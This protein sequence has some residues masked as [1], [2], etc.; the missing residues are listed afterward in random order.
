MLRLPVC[1]DRDEEQL[2]P[3]L[4]MLW[5]KLMLVWVWGFSVEEK[6]KKDL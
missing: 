6:K 2:L 1:R 3:H 5:E 4:E